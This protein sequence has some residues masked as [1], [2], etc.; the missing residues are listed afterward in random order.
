MSILL[1][2][3]KLTKDK[4][5]V[6]G[7]VYRVGEKNVKIDDLSEK[8]KAALDGYI[9]DEIDIP[10]APVPQRGKTELLMMDL[11]TNELFYE[12]V[13]RPLT[14]EEEMEILIEKEEETNDLLRELIKKQDEIIITLRNQV[15]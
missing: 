15:R 12:S 8:E 5:W 4:A 3:Q 11:K 6:D 13:D 7:R 9:I 14:Q 10:E 1:T 2:Y